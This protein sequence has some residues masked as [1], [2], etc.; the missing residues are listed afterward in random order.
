M[1]ADA[2]AYFER[3]MQ[4]PEEVVVE[5]VEEHWVTYR[6]AHG[7]RNTRSKRGFMKHY[8]RLPGSEETLTEITSHAQTNTTDPV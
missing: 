7:R 1:I 6:N 8:S 4:P 3:G 2:P 5:V